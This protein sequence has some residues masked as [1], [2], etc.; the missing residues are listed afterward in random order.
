MSQAHA[1]MAWIVVSVGNIEHFYHYR[2][3]RQP[4]EADTPRPAILLL[5]S[6]A[7]GNIMDVTEIGHHLVEALR[8]VA[9][10]AMSSARS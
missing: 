4:T 3:P 2:S 9:S 7:D 1:Y 6:L 10:Y 8:C 5:D